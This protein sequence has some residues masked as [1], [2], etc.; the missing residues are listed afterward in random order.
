MR[1][2]RLVVGALLLACFAGA[3]PAASQPLRRFAI[4]AGGKNLRT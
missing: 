1:A 3:R 4:T 2:A